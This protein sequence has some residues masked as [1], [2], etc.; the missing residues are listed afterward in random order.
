VRAF[1]DRLSP[2]TV[3][4]RYLGP[5][6]TLA[7]PAGDPELERLL[8]RNAAEHV[9]VLAVDGTEIRGIGEFVAEQVQRAELALVVEDAFQRCGIGRSLF[10]RLER[11]ALRRGIRAFTGDMAYGNARALALLR[12]TGHRFQVQ[13]S[14]GSLQ[15]RLL[16]FQA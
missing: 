7:G 1:L 2:S 9:V 13:P 10:R 14:Y 12:G 11:L 16:L 6:R 8:E 15:F 5:P 4:W 3:Q